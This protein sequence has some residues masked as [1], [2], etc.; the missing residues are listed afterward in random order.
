MSDASVEEV[1]LDAIQAFVSSCPYCPEHRRQF[2]LQELLF[3]VGVEENLGN[4]M[5]LLIKLI[6]TESEAS[7]TDVGGK[8]TEDIDM[9][10]KT[11]SKVS[12]CIFVYYSIKGKSV[13][14]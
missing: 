3:A 10:D 6:S 12:F 13:K 9:N 11:E 2:I 1:I 14:L 7:A 8:S 5:L 4:T